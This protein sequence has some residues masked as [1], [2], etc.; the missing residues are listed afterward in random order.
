MDEVEIGSQIGR[1]P[2]RTEETVVGYQHVVDSA[3]RVV[4]D[5][6][7][8][9][10]LKH[11]PP[12]WDVAAIGRDAIAAV[13]DDCLLDIFDGQG[14]LRRSFKGRGHGVQ[15]FIAREPVLHVSHYDESSPSRESAYTSQLMVLKNGELNNVASLDFAYTFSRSRDGLLLG[16]HNRVSLKV[17]NDV[18]VDPATGKTLRLDLGHYDLFNHYA[19]IDGAPLLFFVQG[20][21]PYSSE[22]KQLCSVDS[23]GAVRRFWPLLEDHGD[24]ASHALEC[25]FEFVADNLGEGLVVAGKHYNSAPATYRG[26][27]YRKSLKGGQELWR[28]PTTASASCIKY[29]PERD[30]VVAAFLDGELAT[31]RASTGEILRW[32]RFMPDGHASVIFSL[33]ADNTQIVAGA[34]DGRIGIAP[35]DTFIDATAA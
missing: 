2:P 32:E 31:L 33:S 4:V 11:R 17:A 10:A 12:I 9:T 6:F 25:C 34:I 14:E 30:I 16:R 19:R 20:T 5:A 7:N 1:L 28:H 35:L 23:S 18:L 13:H 29:I 3:K 24:Q 27:I 15:I 26:F 8:L 22:R 21:P